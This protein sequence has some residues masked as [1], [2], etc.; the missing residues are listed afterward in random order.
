MFGVHT[1]EPLDLIGLGSEQ[2]ERLIDG[3]H[4]LDDS[5]K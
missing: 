4:Q 3:F 5:G 2:L 1:H